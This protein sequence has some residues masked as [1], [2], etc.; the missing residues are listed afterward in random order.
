[1]IDHRSLRVNVQQKQR[2]PG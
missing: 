1:L 2:W